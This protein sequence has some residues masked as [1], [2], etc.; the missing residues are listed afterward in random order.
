MTIKKTIPI[1]IIVATILHLNTFLLVFSINANAQ[2]NIYHPFP[3]SDYV[4]FEISHRDIICPEGGGRISETFSYSLGEDTIINSFIYKK[5]IK[6]ACTTRNCYQGGSGERNYY[7]EPNFQFLRQDS[8]TRKVFCNAN[9]ADSL[10][11]DFNLSV[12][13]TLSPSY[14][15]HDF[16]NINS[17][18]TVSSIDSV[19]VGIQFHKRFILHNSQTTIS[20]FLIEGIGSSLGLFHNLNDIF[21]GFGRL[22]YVTI[23][24]NIVWKS[25]FY[26]TPKILI[27]PYC[28]SGKKDEIT[29][30]PN[31]TKGKFTVYTPEGS[32]I[33]QIYNTLGQRV[34]EKFITNETFSDFYLQNIGIYLVRVKTNNEY[35]IKII[36]IN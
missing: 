34:E 36:I 2:A 14:I 22:E 25:D 15:N 18:I 8:I 12:G 31:P 3:D 7:F 19:L 4:W 29:I 16:Y 33:I 13:D 17:I 23:S 20:S 30:F 10:L 9:G 27:G 5:V 35:L 28:Y 21:F 24:S 6:S 1:L 11:Y 26:S 32:Q